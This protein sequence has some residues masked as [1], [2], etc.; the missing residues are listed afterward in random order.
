MIFTVHLPKLLDMSSFNYTLGA[1][2]FI[3]SFEQKELL[4]IHPIPSCLKSL[5]LSKATYSHKA[6]YCCTVLDSCWFFFLCFSAHWELFRVCSN[7]SGLSHWDLVKWKKLPK[8]G[9]NYF[10]SWPRIKFKSKKYFL[11]SSVEW[12]FEHTYI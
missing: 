3:R 2:I 11:I 1:Y 6:K 12:Q 9:Y 8:R 10:V 7:M 4:F 5:P